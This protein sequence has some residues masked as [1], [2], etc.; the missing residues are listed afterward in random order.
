MSQHFGDA[1][2]D[3]LLNLI[4]LPEYGERSGTNVHCHFKIHQ[5]ISQ[6]NT[7]GFVFVALNTVACVRSRTIG[8]FGC[9]L[10]TTT[11]GD[12]DFLL[13]FKWVQ[14]GPSGPCSDC[15]EQEFGRV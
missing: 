12:Y 9:G 2:F 4:R 6:M 1:G 3:L 11:L 13:G 5:L 7:L 10:R 8:Q 14:A 15:V